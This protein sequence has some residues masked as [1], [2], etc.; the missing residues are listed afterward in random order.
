M[1]A[2][3]EVSINSSDG[4]RREAVTHCFVR[5]EALFTFDWLHGSSEPTK[6]LRKYY[7]KVLMS[8]EIFV[9]T[10]KQLLEMFEPNP[11]D[12]ESARLLPSTTLRCGRHH[13]CLLV[14]CQWEWA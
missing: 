10:P 14:V 12:L 2:V 3:D 8:S 4:W 9:T 5:N 6:T 7:V 13:L 11:D 1:A